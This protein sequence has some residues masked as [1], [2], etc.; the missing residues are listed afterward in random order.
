M[1]LPNFLKC[2][3]NVLTSAAPASADNKSLSFVL[4]SA[5][6]MFVLDLDPAL[7]SLYVGRRPPFSGNKNI[8][9]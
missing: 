5:T 7:L 4:S 9:P 2:S 8:C 1:S 6:V 3:N